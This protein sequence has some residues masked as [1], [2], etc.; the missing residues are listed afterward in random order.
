MKLYHIPHIVKNFV[1]YKYHRKY[2]FVLHA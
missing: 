2:N 1:S